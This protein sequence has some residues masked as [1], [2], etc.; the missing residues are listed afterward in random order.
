MPNMLDLR[1][2]DAN[3]ASYA[4]KV[5]IERKEGP[6]ALFLSRHGVPVLDRHKYAQAGGLLRGAYVL[7]DLGEGDPEIILM[8]SGTEV[9]LIVA[10]GETLA[11]E[12]VNVRLVS[13]PSWGLFKAQPQAYKDEVLLPGVKARLAVEAGVAQGWCRWVGDAG[14]VL[15]VERFGASA[16][17]KVV[18][19]EYGLTVENVLARARALLVG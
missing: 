12:G 15:S 14:D 16:P 19:R 2:G 8:S 1:P 10:A 4:W 11:E 6:T 13:F 17:Q 5:A 9:S 3:E 7:A 18:Y